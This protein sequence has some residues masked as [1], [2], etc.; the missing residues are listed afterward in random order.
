MQ[1]AKVLCLILAMVM[2]SVGTVVVAQNLG[3]STDVPIILPD[4]D[5]NTLMEKPTEGDPSQYDLKEN[6]YIAAGELKRSG[7]FIGEAL[8]NHFRRNGSN[9]SNKRTVVNGNV[10]KQMVTA[11]VVK[12]A[13]QL[14]L[15]GDNYL[16]RKPDKI[17]SISSIKWS[18]S[19]QKYAQDDFIGKFGHRSDALTGYILNDETITDAQWKKSKTV[20]TVTAIFWTRIR[21]P[22]VCC[23]K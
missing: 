21:L 12:N 15:F 23:T 2:A 6:L 17:N 7:G 20:Y 4:D 16:Y 3:D 11:G 22:P 18:N 8:N 9:V 5:Q 1:K 19:A 10:F 14:Y 13:Y